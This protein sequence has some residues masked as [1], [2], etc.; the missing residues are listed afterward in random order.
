MCPAAKP[1]A[2]APESQPA[3]PSAR[4]P[5]ARIR[6][7]GHRRSRRFLLNRDGIGRLALAL[8]ALLCAHPQADGAIAAGGEIWLEEPAGA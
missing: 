5:R 3:T 2:L 8:D 7:G 4:N 6:P 1:P